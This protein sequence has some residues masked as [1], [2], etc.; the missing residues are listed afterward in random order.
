MRRL[1]ISITGGIFI[2][3]VLFGFAMMLVE[4][5]EHKWGLGWMANLLMFS[6]VG[7]VAIWERVF[8][9]LTPCPS[10]GPTDRAIVATIITVFLFYAVLT[11]LIQVVAKRL[12]RTEVRH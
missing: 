8:P 2:P 1:F 3:L 9:H 7:P 5:L 6:F 11:Y 12:R 4:P 10:C